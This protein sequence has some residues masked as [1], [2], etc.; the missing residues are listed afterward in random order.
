MTTEIVSTSFETLKTADGKNRIIIDTDEAPWNDTMSDDGKVNENYAALINMQLI[1]EM[2]QATKT[3]EEN[4]ARKLRAFI[5]CKKLF[6]KEDGGIIGVDVVNDDDEVSELWRKVKQIEAVLNEFVNLCNLIDR[7]NKNGCNAVVIDRCFELCYLLDFVRLHTKGRFHVLSKKMLFDN[8]SSVISV[9]ST[10][11]T[12]KCSVCCERG[13]NAHLSVK[14][15]CGHVFHVSC[16]LKTRA[17]EC[18]CCRT[19]DRFCNF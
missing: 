7:L 9:V 6:K 18:P 12:W 10:V 14:K 15:G 16:A 5:L 4:P 11:P 8:S 13:R 2:Y 19:L 17:P 1:I 3:F